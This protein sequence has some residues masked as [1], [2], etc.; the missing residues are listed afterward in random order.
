MPTEPPGRTPARRDVLF[1]PR[2]QSRLPHRKAPTVARKPTAEPAAT[3]Q[4]TESKKPGTRPRPDRANSQPP[5]PK[6]ASRP[7]P[8]RQPPR[9]GT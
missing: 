3:P 5:T 9:K 4:P 8:R 7:A 2:R 6:R 1:M